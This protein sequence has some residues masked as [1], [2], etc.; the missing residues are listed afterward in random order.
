MG[1]SHLS[2]Y[3]VSGYRSMHPGTLA[4]VTGTKHQILQ[5]LP[6]IDMHGLGCQTE[7]GYLAI[8]GERSPLQLV[9][10]W[11]LQA[12]HLP[13]HRSGGA[14]LL[15]L[16]TGHTDMQHSFPSVNASCCRGNCMTLKLEASDLCPT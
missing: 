6:A 3:N 16:P 14:A 4:A 5:L 8:R 13:G 1:L 11:F 7:L 9:L 15:R 12:L 2:L 10:P